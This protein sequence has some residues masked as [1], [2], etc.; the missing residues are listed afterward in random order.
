MKMPHFSGLY[1]TIMM[2]QIIIILAAMIKLIYD[3]DDMRD[4]ITFHYAATDVFYSKWSTVHQQWY[5][6]DNH[7]KMLIKSYSSY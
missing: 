4:N 1:L 2:I 6:G 5:S 3:I 7:R